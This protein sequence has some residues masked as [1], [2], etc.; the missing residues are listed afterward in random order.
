MGTELTELA[1]YYACDVCGAYHPEDSAG[2]CDNPKT[3]FGYAELD[4]LHPEG[5]VEL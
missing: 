1:A 3:R 5:W 4:A 2:D